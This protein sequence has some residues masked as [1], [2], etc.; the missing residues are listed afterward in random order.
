MSEV[1]KGSIGDLIFRIETLT[2]DRDTIKVCVRAADELSQMQNELS[3][4]R[5]ELALRTQAQRDA[6]AVVEAARESALKEAEQVCREVRDT[7]EDAQDL[8]GKL[9]AEACINNLYDLP[10]AALPAAKDGG[11]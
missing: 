1:I 10:R 4:L 2:S 8:F 3:A 5:A 11:E 6:L 9:A 7:C